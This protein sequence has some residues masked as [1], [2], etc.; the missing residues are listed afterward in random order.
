MYVNQH[1]NLITHRAVA[2]LSGAPVQVVAVGVPLSWNH[3]F[4]GME[5]RYHLSSLCRWL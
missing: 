1:P 3:V 2:R 5:N 4:R